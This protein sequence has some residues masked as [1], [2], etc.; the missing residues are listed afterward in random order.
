MSFKGQ[1]N[2]YTCRH[3]P[4]HIITTLD[5]DDGTTPFLTVCETCKEAGVPGERGFRF[6]VMESSFYRIPQHYP[7]THEWYRP[8]AG[9]AEAK[10]QHYEMGGLFLRKVE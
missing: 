5:V 4:K 2:R 10:G 9:S 3:D 8:V 1:K 7:H 6:P